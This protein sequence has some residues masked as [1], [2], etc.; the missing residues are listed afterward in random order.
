MTAPKNRTDPAV[1]VGVGRD[2]GDANSL[3]AV[4]LNDLR[5]HQAACDCWCRPSQDE[6]EPLVWIHHSLDRREH[7]FEKGK[8]Q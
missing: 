3:H 8:V 1:G 4:P 6:E 2:D 5:E 7:T